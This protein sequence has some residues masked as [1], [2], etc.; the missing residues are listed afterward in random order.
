[1]SIYYE[2]GNG[3]SKS[4]N[5]RKPAISCSRQTDEQI[6]LVWHSPVAVEAAS[7][8]RVLTEVT[9]LELAGRLWEFMKQR[10]RREN[11]VYKGMEVG[12]LGGSVS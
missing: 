7:S 9:E 6:I 5:P 4:H 1:M 8:A 12:W 11:N 10:I 2:L 3:V